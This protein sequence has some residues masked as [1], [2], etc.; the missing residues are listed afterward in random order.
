MNVGDIFKVM[1]GPIV[2]TEVRERH[3]VAPGNR[4]TVRWLDGDT[5]PF[6]ALVYD[7][8]NWVFTSQMLVD[9]HKAAFDALLLQ[10][11]AGKRIEDVKIPLLVGLSDYASAMKA[12]EAAA[13]RLDSLLTVAA[14][15]WAL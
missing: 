11:K 6:D 8:D 3:E 4:C 9:A 12:V 14:K 13:A 15:A 2:I 7:D 10:E 1:S 5:T